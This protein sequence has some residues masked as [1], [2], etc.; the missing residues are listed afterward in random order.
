MTDWREDGQAAHELEL[1]RE[2]R[3]FYLLMA[4]KRAGTPL[5]TIDELAAE[6]GLK[7]EWKQYEA[8]TQP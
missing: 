5:D 3:T 8:S 4:A 1:E 2:Q 6:L 7:R